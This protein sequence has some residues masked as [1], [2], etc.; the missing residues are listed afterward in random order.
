MKKK[1]KKISWKEVIKS[2]FKEYALMAAILFLVTA[3]IVQGSLVPTPSMERTIMTGDRLMINK[4]A[5]GL[6]TPR[7]I[8]FTDIELPHA[9]LIE[10]GSPKK[11]DIV[12]FVFPGNRDEIKY[13]KIENWVKRCVAAPGDT[14]EVINKVVFVNGKQ[15]PIPANI[16]YMNSR[17][18]PDNY[19]EEDMFPKGSRYNS[20]HYGPIVVPKKND[21]ID[22]TVENIDKWETFI[23]REYGKDV[24]D[25]NNGRV[26]IDGKESGRYTVKDDY[27]FMM[28][29]NRDNSLDSRYWGFVPKRNVVGK[30]MFVYFSWNS[31][32][33][34]SDLFELIKSI[35]IERLCRLVN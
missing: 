8:P 24:V 4:L 25:V 31:D 35:R 6:T 23:N 13:N 30:P 33:P 18:K 7:Y 17:T 28:G 29:D 15:L 32:I 1:I 27:Y 16:N 12:V 34:F 19:V 22:L 3:S 10:W 5:Y 26:F 20:D 2:Y 9:R 21:V 14:L 11:G